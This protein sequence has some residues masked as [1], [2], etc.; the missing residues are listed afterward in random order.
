MPINI[1]LFKDSLRLFETRSDNIRRRFYEIL[2]SENPQLDSELS[3]SDK[4]ALTEIFDEG[5]ALLLRQFHTP[6]RLEASLLRLGTKYRGAWMRPQYTSFFRDAFMSALEEEMGTEWS[7]PVYD[8]WDEA[9]G[10]SL[11]IIQR[12]REDSS[13]RA[14]A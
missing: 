4:K 6:D 8:A 14:E 3:V 12:A 7:R 2:C 5:L 9:I 10:M 13:A 1:S 11:S